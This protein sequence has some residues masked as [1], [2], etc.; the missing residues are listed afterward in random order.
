M[1]NGIQKTEWTKMTVRHA[2]PA[3]AAELAAVEAACF[4]K[5]EAATEDFIRE[6]LLSY[7]EHFWLLEDQGRLI[8]FVNGMVTDE[9]DLT[10]EMY[11]FAGMHNPGG[12][13]QM[14]FGVDTIPEYRCRGCAG[15]LLRC[16]IGE[17]REQGREGVVLTCKEKLI[18]YYE[19]FGF[20][21][22]GISV[23]VH[24]DA[25][26]YQMRLRFEEN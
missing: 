7:P 10:D 11:E 15:Y 23:S 4:P 22:E 14:I 18:S 19:K 16:A 21:N 13:W 24:G 2:V 1:E 17:A 6:R 3:D 20:K 26:W 5:A 12:R 8:S 25:V 9:P